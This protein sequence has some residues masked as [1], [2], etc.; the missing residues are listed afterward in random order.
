MNRRRNI[1][2]SHFFVFCFFSP[3]QKEFKWYY[4]WW[5]N[6]PQRAQLCDVVVPLDFVALMND[7][8]CRD[9]SLVTICCATN[10]GI[11]LKVNWVDDGFICFD[12]RMKTKKKNWIKLFQTDF[13]FRRFPPT[14]FP[15]LPPPHT[16]SFRFWRAGFVREQNAIY[17]PTCQPFIENNWNV[18]LIRLKRETTARHVYI[19]RMTVMC[20]LFFLS[21]LSGSFQTTPPQ[22]KKKKKETFAW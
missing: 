22:A 1:G 18:F 16:D 11:F 14:S 9:R 6:G 12:T 15:P 7:L 17:E 13:F 19:K 2:W 3:S 8:C 5:K 4:L 20:I 21:L 10:L